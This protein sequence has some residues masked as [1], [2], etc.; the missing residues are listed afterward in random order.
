MNTIPLDESQKFITAT[1]VFLYPTDTIYWLGGL[2]TPQV[3]EKIKAIKQ[4]PDDKHFSI[5]APHIQR[6]RENFVIHDE[7]E[8]EWGKY[9]QQFPWRWLTLLLPLRQDRPPTTDFSLLSASSRIGVRLIDHPFQEIVAKCG[10]PFISTSANLSWQPNITNPSQLT[11]EQLQLI[12]Y[13]ID[14]WTIDAPSSVIIDYETKQI[15]RA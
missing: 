9:K 5:I 7:I 12:D 14:V 15:I 11:N 4:R 10:E 13:I 3:V 8:T 2:V 6:I 1:C